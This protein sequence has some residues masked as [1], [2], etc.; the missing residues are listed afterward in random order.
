M[1]NKAIASTTKGLDPKTRNVALGNGATVVII[2]PMFM[3]VSWTRSDENGDWKRPEMIMWKLPPSGF[4]PHLV[5]PHANYA[6][7]VT[8]DRVT[9]HCYY[10]GGKVKQSPCSNG[11]IE[12]L[13][14]ENLSD[15]SNVVAYEFVR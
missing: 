5:A 4:S 10:T 12:Y 15:E 2:V 6:L 13:A 3:I 7:S 8:G 14:L 11:P 1:P 9:F